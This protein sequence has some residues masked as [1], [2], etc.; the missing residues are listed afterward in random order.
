[1][2]KVIWDK[3]Q[4]VVYIEFVH[5]AAGCGNRWTSELQITLFHDCR[6][7][8]KLH[9]PKPFL[10]LPLLLNNFQGFLAQSIPAIYEWMTSY[11]NIIDPILALES[12]RRLVIWSLYQSAYKNL[13]GYFEYDYLLPLPYFIIYIISTLCWGVALWDEKAHDLM[14]GWGMNVLW[15]FRHLLPYCMYICEIKLTRELP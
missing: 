11:S 1:M 8:W 2:F 6:N 13:G 3:V 5:S 12:R 9:T 15:P 10:T 14:E 4:L 7:G